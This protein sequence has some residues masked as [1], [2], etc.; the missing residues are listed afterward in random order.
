MTTDD[1]SKNI[2]NLQEKIYSAGD[3]DISK[4]F[5]SDKEIVKNL[6]LSRSPG[7]TKEDAS[8]MVDGFSTATSSVSSGMSQAKDKKDS[9]LSNSNIYPITENHPFYKEIKDI[10]ASIRS[11]AMLITKDQ[12]G[13]IQDLINAALLVG[14]SIPA[15]ALMIASPPW[16]IPSAISLFSLIVDA[17]STIINKA[18]NMMQYLEPLKKLGIVIDFNK[19]S[20]QTSVVIPINIAVLLLTS[21]LSPIVA[22]KKFIDTLI[23]TIKKL[24]NISNLSGQIKKIKKQ[25]RIKKKELSKA[26]NDEDK[27]DISEDI[28]DLEARLSDIEDPNK[29]KEINFNESILSPDIL[30]SFENV[31]KILNNTITVYDAELPDG[32]ILSGLDSDGLESIKQKYNVKF[33]Y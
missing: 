5:L 10:K 27:K 26:T 24:T 15:I 18:M 6:I 25:I 28:S 1:L 16:N 31:N 14:S 32:T 21:I 19:P 33:K 30:S 23:D 8:I 2:N 11:S 12:K 4:F 29:T 20:I 17:I 13:L 9:L 7:M 3:I 22:L